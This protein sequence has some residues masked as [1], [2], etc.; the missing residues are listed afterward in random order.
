VYGS[1]LGTYDAICPIGAS[2]FCRIAVVL[3]SD[4]CDAF[5]TSAG[6]TCLGT[7]SNASATPCEA[8]GFD[9]CSHAGSYD[10]ICNCSLPGTPPPPSSCV[11]RFP[12]GVVCDDTAG[13][14]EVAAPL[15]LYS[16]CGAYCTAWGATCTGAIYNGSGLCSEAAMSS[17]TTV[18]AGS[19]ICLC[20][21]P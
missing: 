5:C 10:A 1:L 11:D 19:E 18:S 3:N 12:D 16:T 15:E 8:D 4:S 17:C 13:T 20:A 14:C 21:P 9:L 2:S 6:G 7:M